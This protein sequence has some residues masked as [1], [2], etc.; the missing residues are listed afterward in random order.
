MKQKILFPRSPCAKPKIVFFSSCKLSPGTVYLRGPTVSTR[1]RF[2]S[3]P[4]RGER[5][6]SSTVLTTTFL[7]LFNTPLIAGRAIEGG[8][9]GDDDGK[10]VRRDWYSNQGP[11]P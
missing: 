5:Y 2:C 4:S 1:F 3:A 6:F 10:M 9:D 11:V 8:T 7:S